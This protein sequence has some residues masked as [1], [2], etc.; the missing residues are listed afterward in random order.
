MGRNEHY[1]ENKSTRADK[2]KQHSAAMERRYAKE[3]QDSSTHTH[4][5]TGKVENLQKRGVPAAQKISVELIDSVTAVTMYAT[6]MYG[7]PA[8]LNFASYKNPGGMFLNGSKA[9][10]ECL[11]HESNLY[12]ILVQHERYYEENHKNLNRALYRNRVLYSPMVVFER[13]KIAYRCD[14]TALH[15]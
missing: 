11:C 6:G 12:N 13:D 4:T 1:W 3:I 15:G 2:A 7:K 9:Q 8:V 14:L 10:E 5:Y